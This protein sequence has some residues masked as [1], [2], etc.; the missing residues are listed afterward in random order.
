MTL[1]YL[2]NPLTRER[3][4]GRIPGPGLFPEA[5]PETILARGVEVG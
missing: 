2:C 1:A 4:I 5:N 3:H